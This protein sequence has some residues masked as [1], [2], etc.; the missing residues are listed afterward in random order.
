M[1]F[2]YCDESGTGAEP[3][4]VMVG[5]VVDHHR[6]D[7]TKRDWDQ[8]LDELSSLAGRRISEIHTRNFYRG[9]GIWQGLTAE[10]R[11]KIITRI[12]EWLAERKHS[13]V[14]AS[15]NKTVFE[16]N[17][18]KDKIPAELY[19]PW[20]FLGFHLLLAIQRYCGKEFDKKKGHTV[21]VFD[22][23]KHEEARF[24][25]LVLR[26]PAWSDEY[27]ERERRQDAMDQIVDVPYFGDS[28]EIGLIQVADVAAFFLRRYAEIKEGLIP[29]KYAGEE[30]RVTQWMEEFAALSI[31]RPHIYCQRGRSWSQELFF[32]NAPKSISSL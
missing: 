3:I 22:S 8:L 14:Y 4:A 30:Q 12:F 2:C 31:G 20:R 1:K 23:E 29:A 5:I 17:R 13:V 21:V 27:Y 10:T 25:D 28:K 18:A 24:P 15:V 32:D 11:T 16:S 6:M 19:N 7:I 9:N 26:P